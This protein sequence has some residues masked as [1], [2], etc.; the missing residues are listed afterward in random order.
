MALAFA[1]VLGVDETATLNFI[2]DTQKPAGFSLQQTDPDSDASL[3]Y[4]AALRIAGG[5]GPGVPDGGSTMALLLGAGV[6]LAGYRV[7]SRES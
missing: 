3:Y 1:F 7:R 5:G 6:V 2:V 4:S